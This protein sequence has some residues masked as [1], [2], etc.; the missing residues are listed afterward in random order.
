ML[1]HQTYEDIFHNALVVGG[2]INHGSD[3]KDKLGGGEDEKG[4]VHDVV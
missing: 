3:E 2:M 4:V 1:A